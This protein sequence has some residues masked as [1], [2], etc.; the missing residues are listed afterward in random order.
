MLKDMLERTGAVKFGDFTLSSGKESNIYID[1]K[2]ACTY[3]EV[4]SKISELVINKLGEKGIEYHKIAC[5]ELGGVPLAVSLSIV[6]GKPY[7]IFRK[8]EKGY[9]TGGDVIGSIE[10]C[11]KVIIIEDVTTT[12]GSA[13]SAVKRV[14]KLKGNVEAVISVVDRGEGAE[15]L[16]ANQ[17]V[18][19]IPLLTKKELLE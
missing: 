8:E 3:P 5:V 1:I 4:L 6:T 16:F 15:E 10:E 7:A 9:G 18:E 17:N 19:F 14:E 13:R 12:G 2:I 11:E